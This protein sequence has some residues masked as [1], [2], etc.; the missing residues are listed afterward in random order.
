M[1][2]YERLILT[3]YHGFDNGEM[4]LGNTCG[5]VT[6]Y[7]Q[8]SSIA[9][10]I[11]A[12]L[13][14]ERKRVEYVPKTKRQYEMPIKWKRDIILTIRCSFN[15]KVNH[16]NG[17][18]IDAIGEAFPRWTWRGQGEPIFVLNKPTSLSPSEQVAKDIVRGLHF[19]I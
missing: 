6:E 14:D 11:Y 13:C 3:T 5:S 19:I 18:Y 2:R 9:A 7:D 17:T 15:S 16:I 8:E 12:L 10:L 4:K 1:A